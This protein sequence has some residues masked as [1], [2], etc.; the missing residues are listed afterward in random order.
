MGRS[1]PQCLQTI[2]SSLIIS[3]QYGHLLVYPLDAR[4]GSTA[5]TTISRGK[6]THSINHNTGLRP[7]L[8]AI[9]L[10]AMPAIISRITYLNNG[11]LYFLLSIRL[12]FMYISHPNK[13]HG[14]SASNLREY[15]I[16]FIYSP[17]IGLYLSKL[18]KVR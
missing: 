11:N 2:A 5:I 8:A 7:F 9:M 15:P 10:P 13:W 14:S 16:P 17:E 4:G 18:Y 6:R 12:F 1:L 3:A